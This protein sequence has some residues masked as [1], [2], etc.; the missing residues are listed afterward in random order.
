[1]LPDIHVRQQREVLWQFI[2]R[3]LGVLAPMFRW[4]KVYGEP[5]RG[6]WEYL[7]LDGR[8]FVPPLM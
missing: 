4:T 2:R 8:D 3:G 1:M 5:V 7:P 6:D